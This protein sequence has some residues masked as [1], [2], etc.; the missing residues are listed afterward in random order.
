MVLREEALKR[1]QLAFH[2]TYVDF[3]RDAIFLNG[4]LLATR[5][6]YS[7]YTMEP[8]LEIVLMGH[9]DHKDFF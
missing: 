3:D 6:T 7:D 8:A 9:T 5:H 1:Y 4:N 2:E